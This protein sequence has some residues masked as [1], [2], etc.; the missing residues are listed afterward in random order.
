MSIICK[1]SLGKLLE[2]TMNDEKII[3][4]L[5][6]HY[7]DPDGRGMHKLCLSEYEFKICLNFMLDNH[8]EWRTCDPK[9][10]MK[11]VMPKF[12]GCANPNTIL[13]WIKHIR[14]N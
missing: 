10:I 12:G 2:T 9:E 4:Y 7:F 5:D 11:Y 3:E 13:D 6:K 8:P 14:V 1:P